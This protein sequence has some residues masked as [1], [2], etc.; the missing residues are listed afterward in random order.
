MYCRKPL[1]DIWTDYRLPNMSLLKIGVGSDRLRMTAA[2]D[3]DDYRLIKFWNSFVRHVLDTSQFGQSTR[4]TTALSTSRPTP[5]TTVETTTTRSTT[6]RTTTRRT[7]PTTQMPTTTADLSPT[8]V[9]TTVP[10][11]TAI[12]EDADSSISS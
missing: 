2:A 4:S 11:T 9:R 8:T 1:Y 10:V 7:V 3:D 12:D 5:T 6:V